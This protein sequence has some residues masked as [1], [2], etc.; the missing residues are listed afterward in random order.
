MEQEN[1]CIRFHNESERNLV[2]RIV[3]VSRDR[4][5]VDVDAAVEID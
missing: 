5:L 4:L 3:R 1:G 2:G